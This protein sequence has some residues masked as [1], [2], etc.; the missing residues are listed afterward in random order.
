MKRQ[1]GECIE[2]LRTHYVDP[3]FQNLGCLVFLL[4]FSA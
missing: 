2:V 3:R 4:Q 1:A